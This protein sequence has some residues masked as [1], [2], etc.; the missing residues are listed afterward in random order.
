MKKLKRDLYGRVFYL[1]VPVDDVA[2]PVEPVHPGGDPDGNVQLPFEGE[3][4]VPLGVVDEPP[5]VPARHQLRDDHD[6][7]CRRPKEQHHVGVVRLLHHVDLPPE[8]LRPL[9]AQLRGVGDLHRPLPPAALAFVHGPE[10]SFPEEVLLGAVRDLLGVDV[11]RSLSLGLALE[12]PVLDFLD[13]IEGLLCDTRVLY[14][15]AGNELLDLFGVAPDLPEHLI[16]IP[17]FD[18]GLSLGEK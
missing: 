7:V 8:L 14:C 10:G 13:G 18:P 15:S 1:K 17:A 2:N 16:G 5:E 9:R 12:E 3:R 11:G 6:R 4:P